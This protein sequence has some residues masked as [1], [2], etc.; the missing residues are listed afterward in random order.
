MSVQ[1]VYVECVLSLCLLPSHSLHVAVRLLVLCVP[2]VLVWACGCVC[3]PRQPER[4]TQKNLRVFLCRSL[5]VPQFLVPD[6]SLSLSV[7]KQLNEIACVSC[8]LLLVS[9]CMSVSESV[10]PS[11]CVACVLFVM[12]IRV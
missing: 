1:R 10:S 12:A 6:L 4:S 9:A 3:E 8:Y 5:C 7:R 11:L 2:C